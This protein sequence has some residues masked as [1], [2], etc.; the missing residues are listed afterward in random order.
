MAQGK[1]RGFSSA[2]GLIQYYDME[3]TKALKVPPEIVV[4]LGIA[5]GVLVE[6]LAWKFPT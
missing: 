5:V 6:V 3:E 1:N 4:I 2:A